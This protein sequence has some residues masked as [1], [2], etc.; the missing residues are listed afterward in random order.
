MDA[1]KVEVGVRLLALNND[2][3]ITADGD[4]YGCCSWI[5]ITI[6]VLGA[7]LMALGVNLQKFSINREI[8]MHP[9]A[10]RQR[11]LWCQPIWVLGIVSYGASGGLLSA[12]LAFAPQSQLA[13][14]MSV[15]IIANALLARFFL[16]E[17]LTKRDVVSIMIIVVAVI[18]TTIAAPNSH[19]TY[20]TDDLIALYKEPGFIVF[21][22]LLLTS[23]LVLSYVNFTLGKKK[24]LGLE[25]DEIALSNMEEMGYAFTFG[26][27][28]GCWGGLSV[29]LMKSAITILVYEAGEG[30]A[31]SFFSTWLFYPILFILVLCWVFQ[32]SWINGGLLYYPAVFVV[33]I[34][35][36]LNEIVGVCGGILYFQE[37]TY[38]SLGE[39]LTFGFGI[40]LGIY[41]IV[42]FAIRDNNVSLEEDVFRCCRC[43]SAGQV[44]ERGSSKMRIDQETTHQHQARR[45][46]T[47]NPSESSESCTETDHG[48]Y[49]FE[50]T[51]SVMEIT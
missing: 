23:M 7:I 14:L 49:E 6:Y 30:G 39:G 44:H 13:P 1:V 25:E 21:M 40:F 50:N 48:N 43:K 45:K 31:K 42:L 38:F 20:T 4:E 47:R 5:G 35:A 28:A 16:G 46:Q 24:R 2:T 37:Y 11:S 41:G 32:L 3:N 33:S 26:A 34:E 19:Q 8:K 29:T 27:S 17:P 9:D 22:C 36:V 18:L 10:E 12:A 15:V 51:V